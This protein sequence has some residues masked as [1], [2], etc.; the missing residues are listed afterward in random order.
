MPCLQGT[1]LFFCFRLVYAGWFYWWGD[2]GWMVG[3]YN[4]AGEATL[5]GHSLEWHG[6]GD[7][8]RK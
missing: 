5:F 1:S 8:Q 7:A 2:G 4:A 3:R 6:W